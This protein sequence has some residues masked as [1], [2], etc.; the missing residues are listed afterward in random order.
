M[1]EEAGTMTIMMIFF[2]T[3]S[4]AQQRFSTENGALT[5]NST[6]LAKSQGIATCMVKDLACGEF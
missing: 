1:K 2:R 4:T 3:Q 6:S 5:P